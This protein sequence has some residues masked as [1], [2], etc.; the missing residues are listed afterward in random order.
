M[1]DAVC[2]ASEHLTRYGGHPFAA[3]MSLDSEKIGD[4]RKAVNEF[5]AKNFLQMPVYTQ[6]ID[7]VMDPAELTVNN[8]S[9]L[10]LLE[11]VGASNEVP[12]F[13]FRKVLV[14]G[15]YPIGNG[16]HLR[17]RFK[18]SRNGFLCGLFWND[19]RRIPLCSGR[20]C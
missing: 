18:K 19:S 3:G 11:P 9:S 7:K 5:A 16:K 12:V 13:A 1:I 6:K 10:K 17:L 15:I 20:N 8:I 14:D 4:F 2:Y